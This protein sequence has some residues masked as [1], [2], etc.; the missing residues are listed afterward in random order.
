M[1]PL[2][3]APNT[4]A[5][6]LRISDEER[7]G[8]VDELGTHL[9]AGRLTIS[10][11]DDRVATVY[12]ARTRAEADTVL[13]DLPSADPSP[14]RAPR[15][16]APSTA[17]RTR[18]TFAGLPLH[19]R[20]EWGGWLAAGSVNLVV[21]AL[22]SLGTGSFVYFWPVWVIVPWGLVLAVRTGLGL[23]GPLTHGAQV[24]RGAPYPHCGRRA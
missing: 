9:T 15:S 14:A 6:P 16:A 13:A 2:S 21:W 24:H 4:P 20:I 5:S 22:V 3:A 8:L 12:R 18:R 19:Q 11:F 10:E 17:G 7:S 1:E 23:E